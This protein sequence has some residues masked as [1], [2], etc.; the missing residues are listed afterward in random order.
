MEKWKTPMFHD[1]KR[2][3]YITNSV[4]VH[5]TVIFLNK[6]KGESERPEP[7]EK[8]AQS[9]FFLCQNGLI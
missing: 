4:R 6:M 2:S 9:L 1:V 7:V 5:G 3:D 8:L